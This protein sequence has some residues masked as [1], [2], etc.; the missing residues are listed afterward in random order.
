MS[1]FW[2]DLMESDESAANYMTSYG[3]GPGCATRLTIA[4]FIN[5]GETV[6][7]VGCGPGW[8]ADHFYEFGPEIDDY[9]GIDYS[10]RFVRIANKRWD[11][12]ELDRDFPP[13]HNIGEPL[14]SKGDARKLNF[15]PD[16]YDVVILQDVLDH[17]PG[18]EKPMEQALRVAARRVIVSFWRGQMRSAYTNDNGEDMIRDD[19]NDGWTGEYSRKKW[20]TYLDGLGYMWMGTESDEQAN[21]WHAF[22][23]VDKEEPK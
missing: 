12:K 4:S 17:T 1:N 18:Y 5:P 20:E 23:I 8:N 13:L 7:D 3:E 2:D 6:L 10:D 22:Y 11:S 9:K 15:A 19:G 14:F 21:R 16:E